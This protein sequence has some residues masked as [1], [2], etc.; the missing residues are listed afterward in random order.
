[1]L[2]ENKNAVLYGG[3]G[4]IGGAVARAFAREGATVHLAG[5]TMSTLQRVAD[6]IRAAGGKAEVAQ[7]DAFDADQVDE[8]ADSVA[9]GGGSL[10]V[11]FNI[12]SHPDHMGTPAVRMSYEDFEEPVTRRLRTMWITSRAA[13]RHMVEQDSGVILA[14]GGYGDPVPN[15]GG[16]QVSF[17]AVEAFRRT[18]ARELGPKGI[19]VI[20]L[21]T[22]GIPEGIPDE[23]TRSAVEKSIAERTMLGR[24]ATLADVG[25]A[26]VFAASDW[27]RALTGTKLNITCGS[28][29][30]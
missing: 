19:R 12:I 27:S 18:L 1:M 14:Y 11:S 17:G 24:A 7:V 15:Y 21:Q 13:A 25:N 5:R 29:P 26:A 2:L 16:F 3:G 9:A 22:G 23:R 4:T 10:D 8:H 30:D 6:E 20:T 28:V